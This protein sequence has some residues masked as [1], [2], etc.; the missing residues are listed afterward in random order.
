MQ[1]QMFLDFNMVMDMMKKNLFMI[2]LQIFM[3]VW[4]NFFFFGFVVVKIL[5]FFMQWFWFMLQNGIDLSFVDVSYVSSW[6]WYFLNLFGF[7][8]LFSLIFGE[9]NV[10][11]DIQRMMQMQMVMQMGGFG[12]DLVK[13]FGVEKDGLDLVQYEW[14][15]FKSE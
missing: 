11:D 3:F 8:G 5:F 1:V 6:L 12:V 14:V 13:V 2:I 4:V 15:F 10:I 7:W 9:E